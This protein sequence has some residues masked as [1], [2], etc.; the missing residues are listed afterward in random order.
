L[1]LCASLGVR[2]VY[3]LALAC[4][5][6]PQAGPAAALEAGEAGAIA[7]GDVIRIVNA[8]QPANLSGVRVEGDLDLS[9]I[10]TVT[11]PLRCQGC[12]FTGKVVATDLIL[13]RIVDLS[14][15]VFDGPVDFSAA[16]FRDRAGFE[17]VLFNQGATFGSTRFLAD[18]SFAQTRFGGPAVFDRAQFGAG[19]LFSD[20]SFASDAGFQATQFGAGADFAGSEFR[21]ASNFTSTSFG[22]RVSFARSRFTRVAEFRGAALSGGANMGVEKFNE[23]F[24]LEAVTAAGSIEFLGA[25]LQG[26][27]A[28]NNFSSTGV[29]ALDGIRLLGPDSAIFL[30]QLSVSRLTMDV[31]QIGAAQGRNVQ[32]TVLELVEKSGRESGDLALANRARFQLLD[33]EGEEKEGFARL[34]DRL[35]FRDVSGYLV[36]PLHPLVTLLILVFIGGMVRSA[37]SLRIGVTGWW[38]SRSS[39]QSPATV[40]DRLR[41]ALLLSEKAVSRVLGGV[42]KAMNVAVRRKPDHIKLENP[43]RVSDYLKVGLLWGEFLTYKLVFAVFVLALGNSNST[44]RQLLDAVTG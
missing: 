30:D 40:W 17:N 4:W 32:K 25:A 11:R 26:E 9:G 29:L 27:G 6:L 8:G 14:G 43:D 28:F 20:T 22:K 31:E 12:R 18:A 42:S 38:S 10:E 1:R 21:G 15:S 34:V 13:E 44:V 41:R 36:R 24:S 23:G 2:A 33:L 7:A 39:R 35:L 3:C 5:L 19:A 37:R 16:L